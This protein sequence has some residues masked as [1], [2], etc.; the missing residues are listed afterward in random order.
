MVLVLLYDPDLDHLDR[1]DL[2]YFV[3]GTK[4]SHNRKENSISSS[5]SSSCTTHPVEIKSFYPSYPHR[6]DY[7]E[8]P[9]FLQIHHIRVSRPSHYVQYPPP[10]PWYVRRHNM[11][12]Q[13]PLQRKS[14][15]HYVPQIS[16][17]SFVV[18]W[19]G[20]CKTVPR[21]GG[22]WRMVLYKGQIHSHVSNSWKNVCNIPPEWWFRVAHASLPRMK[23]T[24]THPHF[25]PHYS[26]L[27]RLRCHYWNS[28]NLVCM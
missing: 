26:C 18:G 3:P 10:F 14:R 22:A 28:W 23:V 24:T 11:H 21:E 15:V 5:L 1:L 2:H 19:E 16:F 27:L 13:R 12:R 7:G 20:D 17:R 4:A 8:S 9:Y 25:H 6:L